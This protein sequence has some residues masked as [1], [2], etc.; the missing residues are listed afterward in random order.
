MIR[1]HQGFLFAESDPHRGTALS[2]YLPAAGQHSDGQAA[3]RPASRWNGETR[4]LV[5]DD[6]ETVRD[7]TEKML[8]R[9][10][11]KVTMTRDGE[12]AVRLFRNERDRG[13]PFHVGDFWT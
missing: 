4:I 11:H 9:L 8:E 13:H 5:M 6:E 2:F 3:S 7:I 10:G 1:N 12:E